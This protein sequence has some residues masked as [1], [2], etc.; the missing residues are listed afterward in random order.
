MNIIQTVPHVCKEASGPSYS[1]TR[2]CDHLAGSGHEVNL[3]T[4]DASKRA[5]AIDYE[6]EIFASSPVIARLGISPGMATSLRQRAIEADVIHNHSLWM[7]PNVYPG[8]AARQSGKPLVVS[9]RGTLTPG[10][11][12]YSASAKKAFWWLHQR[13]AVEQAFCLHATS[14][15]EYQDIRAFGL[16]QPVAVIPNGADIPE[17]P[18]AQ[19]KSTPYTLL[20][21]GRIHHKKG[22]DLLLNAWGELHGA[23]EDW[24]LVIAGSDVH[25]YQA[26]LQDI[27]A[28]RS[29]PRIRFPGPLYGD[30]KHRTY[31]GAS[32]FVLPSRTENFGNTVT[33]ALSR[34]VPV[35]TTTGTPW[36]PVADNGCGWCVEPK[37]AALTEALREAMNCPAAELARMGANGRA[38][39]K[40]DY[41]WEAI[42]E[43]M[44]RTYAWCTGKGPAPD[45]VRFD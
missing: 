16:T 26:E 10:A 45:W 24:Q 15:Q 39:M 19:Q 20:F 21:L 37:A 35:V 2:L 44:V 25:D 12:T 3:M 14:D 32:L 17:L 28:R 42:A 34:R 27:C 23:F 1:V 4:L 41:A 40:R 36:G 38:W 33:E 5:D 6:H 13:R 18:A 7:M 9:P 29:L 22:I 31:M 43:R 8:T 30:E 11:L